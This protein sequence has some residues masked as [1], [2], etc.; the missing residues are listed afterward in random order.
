MAWVSSSPAR[1]WLRDRDPGRKGVEPAQRTGVQSPGLYKGFLCPVHKGSGLQHRWLLHATHVNPVRRHA[2]VN[3]Q[4]ESSLLQ[5]PH[6]GL[7]TPTEIS[8][9]IAR[10]TYCPEYSPL[11]LLC[12]LLSALRS[13]SPAPSCTCL[14]AGASPDYCRPFSQRRA[15]KRGS[16]HT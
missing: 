1:Y 4:R 6:P 9:G 14:R 13:C 3:W 11:P 15:E 12:W 2:G 7:E 5:P 16:P 10:E 8:L